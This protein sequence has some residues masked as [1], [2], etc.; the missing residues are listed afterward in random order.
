MGHRAASRTFGGACVYCRRTAP[1]AACA[2][3]I[4][5]RCCMCTRQSPQTEFDMQRQA[6]RRCCTW[7]LICACDIFSVKRSNLG[8]SDHMRPTTNSEFLFLE[9]VPHTCYI[10]YESSNLDALNG[11]NSVIRL[12]RIDFRFSVSIR[13]LISESQRDTADRQAEMPQ[14]NMA[15]RAKRVF[16]VAF[17]RYLCARRT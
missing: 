1:S 17:A 12:R 16:L 3:L 4:Y 7:H 2:V 11:R 9:N 6:A 15:D 5:F 8:Q 10:I 14:I 13:N